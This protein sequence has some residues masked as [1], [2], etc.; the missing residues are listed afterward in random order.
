MNSSIQNVY[1]RNHKN[2]ALKIGWG[3]F[4]LGHSRMAYFRYSFR[5]VCKIAKSNY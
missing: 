3:C 5:R 1:Y 2:P 4:N